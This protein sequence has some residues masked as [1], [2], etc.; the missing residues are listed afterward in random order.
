MNLELIVFNLFHS[1]A[2]KSGV[3][4]QIIIFF[5]KHLPYFLAIV[6]FILLVKLKPWKKRV[7]FLIL[8]ALTLILSRG[9]LTEVIRF[10]W[11]R[12]RPF[13]ALNFDP[14]LIDNHYA[15]PSGHMAFYF[16]LALVLFSF[17]KKIGYW[18]MFLAVL[19]GVAR[20]IAGVHW[21]SDILGGVLISLIAFFVVRRLMQRYNPV[22]SAV[23]IEL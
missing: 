10:L 5:A 16:A 9:I 13:K 14:L 11:H 17:N 3:V 7:Y 4:D 8:T 20:V 18:F 2:G 1:L 6:A 21:P 12:E 23:K 19:N 15:F 22:Q